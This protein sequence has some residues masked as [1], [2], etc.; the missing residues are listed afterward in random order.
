MELVALMT[1]SP[2]V[3]RAT[4]PQG[5]GTI[6]YAA[7]TELYGTLI[8]PRENSYRSSTWAMERHSRASSVKLTIGEEQRN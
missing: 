6:L 7:F 8:E 1:R 4:T 5:T 2:K 3:S